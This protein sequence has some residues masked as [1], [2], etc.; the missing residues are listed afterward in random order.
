MPRR[1]TKSIGASIAAQAQA[2]AE[3]SACDAANVTSLNLR[4]RL[5]SRVDRT[6]DLENGGPRIRVIIPGGTE[7]EIYDLTH[8]HRHPEFAGLIAEG[9]RCWAHSVSS[10]SRYN[11]L[12]QLNCG[13]AS[14][15]DSFPPDSVNPHSI[16]EAFWTRYIRFLDAPKVGGKPWA[17]AT[18]AKALGAVR[19]CIAALENHAVWGDEAKHL[20]YH[21][22][23]PS[24]PWPGRTS[25]SK[26]TEVILPHEV[27]RLLTACLADVAAIRTRLERNAALL[28]VGKEELQVARALGEEPDF[29][30]LHVCAAYVHEAFPTRLASLADLRRLNLRLPGAI[31][32]N[33]GLGAVRQILY[34]TFGDLVPFVTLIGFKTIFN[35]DALLSLEWSA[36]ESSFD[37]TMIIFNAQKGRSNRTQT[38]THQAGETAAEVRLPAENGTSMGLQDLLNLLNRLTNHTRAILAD[39]ADA[40][41]VFVGVPQRRAWASKAFNTDGHNRDITWTWALQAFITRHNLAP[42]TLKMIRA[43]GADQTRRDFG[44]FAQQERQGHANPQT[45]RTF[46]TSDWVRKQGQDRIGQTQDLYVRA[47]ETNGRIDPRGLGSNGMEGAAT[48]GF[49]CVDPY[50]S[51]RPS[52]EKGKL[53]A[54]YGECPSCPLA[55]A[56]PYNDEEAARYLALRKAIYAGQQGRVS[57]VQ[58]QEKWLPILRDLEALLQQVPRQ[59]MNTAERYHLALPPIG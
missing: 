6:P 20:I 52:Q 45:T 44:I 26:P 5:H 36:I 23:F 22:G 29:A 18:R 59:V 46:Y 47:A 57:A 27:D 43:T 53:C 19:L 13:L 25:K 14:H 31:K 34:N 48:P 32:R 49:L 38:S 7:P 12:G 15:L 42:F 50:A 17:L 3:K 55:A 40:D 16:D 9:F 4:D 28:E 54:A 51:P 21:S 39:D 2:R 11:I 37:D 1:K 8:F 24:N 58:W 30:R 33:H 41:R 35:S 10:R 56:Q